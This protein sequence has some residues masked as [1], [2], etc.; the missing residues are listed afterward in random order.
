MHLSPIVVDLSGT[1]HHDSAAQPG[2]KQDASFEEV[3]RPTS[4]S[5]AESGIKLRLRNRT[6]NYEVG[7]VKTSQS[8]SSHYFK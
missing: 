7:V 6:W 5:V 3:Q 8:L 1:D 4:E 2:S